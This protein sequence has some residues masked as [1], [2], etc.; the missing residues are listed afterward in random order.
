[1]RNQS[2][3][4][5]IELIIVVTIIGIL[6]VA[7]GLEFVGWRGRSAVEVTTRDLY[8]DL[9]NARVSAMNRNRDYFVTAT[10]NTY[11]IYEDTNPPPDGDG[12][13]QTAGDR[14]LQGFPKTVE[15]AICPRAGYTLPVVISKRGMVSFF[16]APSLEPADGPYFRID[17]DGNC[18]L[19]H[20]SP[21]Q[22]KNADYD[23]VNIQNETRIKMGKWN[24][25]TNVCDIK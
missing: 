1:M 13:L 9:M 3:V 5:L 22:E 12:V 16:A 15:Y 10:T 20:D 2:G 8:N 21:N 23:C 25:T 14:I 24:V 18:A 6:I 4:T 17:P 19:P 11:T 7:L